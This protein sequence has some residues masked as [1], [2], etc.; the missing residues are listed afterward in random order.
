MPCS[1][2][3]E[4]LSRDS[5]APLS[6]MKSCLYVSLCGCWCLCLP[7]NALIVVGSAGF[8]NELHTVNHPDRK[9]KK[10][11][12]PE[13]FQKLVDFGVDMPAS[14]QPCAVAGIS[15]ATTAAELLAAAVVPWVGAFAGGS[16]ENGQ[17]F[18][19]LQVPLGKNKQGTL[20]FG[21]SGL[22]PSPT[23]Y[24]F[25]PWPLPWEGLPL[26]SPGFL[27]LSHPSL[28]HPC[29]YLPLLSPLP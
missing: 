16:C 3:A 19:R 12:K 25:L 1:T 17:F 26:A 24:P 21:A 29:L 6:A 23:L 27:F 7:G 11:L 13:R 22:P 2:N 18:P 28:F 14:E 8:T 9:R 20:A 5:P 10:E 4:T 15:R